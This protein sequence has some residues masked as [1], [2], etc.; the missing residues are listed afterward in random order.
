MESRDDD[1]S[2]VLIELSSGNEGK[3]SNS[4]YTNSGS[5]AT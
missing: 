2:G 5:Y 3:N 1:E 4:Y